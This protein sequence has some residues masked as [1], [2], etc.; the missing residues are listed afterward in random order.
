MPPKPLFSLPDEYIR[1]DPR[2]KKDEIRIYLVKMEKS[3]KSQQSCIEYIKSKSI[4][5]V[6]NLS[7]DTDTNE[8]Y[9]PIQSHT[10]IIALLQKHIPTCPIDVIPPCYYALLTRKCNNKILDKDTARERIGAK[11]FDIL[12]PYQIDGVLY[13]IQ[14]DGRVLIGDE[15]GLGKTK[16]AI[17]ML[18]YFKSKTL[19]ICPSLLRIGWERELL[20][21]SNI[22]AI[23]NFQQLQP[24]ISSE[25]EVD[26]YDLD[27][28][29]PLN[30]D[31]TKFE[32]Q[33]VKQ[34]RERKKQLVRM[35]KERKRHMAAYEERRLDLDKYLQ[36]IKS[37]KDKI[38]GNIVII[39]YTMAAASKE[40]IKQLTNAG[41]QT[42]VLDEAH[43]IKNEKSKRTKSI[44]KLCDTMN[45]RILVTG[46]PLDRPQNLYTQISAIDKTI[47]PEFFP[48]CYLNINQ[49]R[50]MAVSKP[51]YSTRYCNPVEQK[52]SFKDSRFTHTGHDRLEELHAI[53]KNCLLIRRLKKDV[54]D[55]PEKFREKI[56]LGYVDQDGK[57]EIKDGEN[58]KKR[59]FQTTNTLCDSEESLQ[60][61]MV[62]MEKWNETGKVLK[63][64]FV[65]EYCKTVIV[66]LL[67]E[68]E[69][70]KIILFAHHKNMMDLLETV[71]IESDIGYMRID[72]DTPMKKRQD[73]IDA[74][75]SESKDVRVAILSITSCA[76]GVTLT[77]SN[78]I[79]MCELV[80]SPQIHAQ[81]EDRSHRISQKNNVTIQYLVLNGTTDDR[82]WRMLIEKTDVA[83]RTLDND[84][85]NEKMSAKRVKFNG[86]V[87]V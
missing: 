61:D 59:K 38:V 35:K 46:S 45:Q 60:K 55:L 82:L 87:T 56:I 72:G 15:M 69:N 79:V 3:V 2:C 66:P 62:F 20:N 32:K 21:F 68:N 9:G 63:L 4:D 22:D 58:V 26:I 27:D 29:L 71:F 77:R 18:N 31:R 67:N 43:Y 19:I 73:S 7:L 44:L 74:F 53:L 1:L 25:K 48:P 49:Q 8:L 84:D 28:D 37:G 75:Q 36:V 6:K 17:A 81:A 40:M 80:F 34:R 76:T 10:S 13:G 16:Q 39:S 83:S 50:N 5:L 23:A 41:F 57:D 51:Y 64:P 30:A 52:I 11:L 65:E 47:F 14:H 54:L 70:Q 85:S 33:I 24:F 78:L 12:F 42:I 86:T